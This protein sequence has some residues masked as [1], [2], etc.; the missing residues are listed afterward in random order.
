MEMKQK[1]RNGIVGCIF[2]AVAVSFIG[3]G[4]GKVVV[5]PNQS[6]APSALVAPAPAAAAPVVVTV[7]A[8]P[9]PPSEDMAAGV[10]PGEDYVWVKGYYNW[11]GN[12]YHWVSGSW[13]RTPRRG[14][15]WD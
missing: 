1:F 5:V 2:A 6:P 8:T 13:V 12:S 9:N 15:V 4:G 11:D 10:S 3:C 14:T 7:P